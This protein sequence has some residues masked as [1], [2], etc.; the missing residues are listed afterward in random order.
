MAILLL[1]R[2]GKTQANANGVLTG[3]TPGV[4]LDDDGKTQ[5]KTLATRLSSIPLARFVVSPLQR[6]QETMA[7]VRAERP[8]AGP[9]PIVDE[10][11]IEVGY[12]SWEG[13]ELKSLAKESLWRVVQATPSAA[14]FPDG[15]SL[16]EV[17]ARAVAAVRE[18]DAAVEAEHGPDALWLAI[19]HGDVIKAIL[20][21]ALGLHLDQFQRIVVNPS[22]VSVIRYEPLRPFVDRVNDTGSDLAPL[23]AKEPRRERGSA[24]EQESDAAVGGATG[25]AQA[26][27]S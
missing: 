26:T 15:E 25:A 16:R 23:V 22:S 24:D 19:S 3:R 5:A 20:A 18:H 2:H 9:E 14:T 4:G 6:C 17:S 10:R 11:L 13:R 7:A 8:E 1:A 21:D 12:G 27:E